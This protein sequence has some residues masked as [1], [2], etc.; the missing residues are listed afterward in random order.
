MLPSSARF[1]KLQ[2]NMSRDH[3]IVVRIPKAWALGETVDTDGLY[4]AAKELCEQI[5]NMLD[6]GELDA[7]KARLR[8]ERKLKELV[9][10]K[11]EAEPKEAPDPP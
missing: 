9:K 7:D 4:K 8:L 3:G 6:K 5:K 11:P 1:L 10:P 2:Q